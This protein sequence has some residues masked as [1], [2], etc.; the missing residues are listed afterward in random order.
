MTYVKFAVSYKELDDDLVARLKAA[1]AELVKVRGEAQQVFLKSAKG[2]GVTAMASVKYNQPAV[3]FKWPEISST[4]PTHGF[5]VS[6]EVT[7]DYEAK[8]RFAVAPAIG[9]KTM[10]LLLS[11][12]LL[13]DAEKKALI[14]RCGVDLDD[15]SEKAGA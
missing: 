7:E 12:K 15:L 8:N 2:L 11:G 9:E 5:S 3:T 10:N 14:K 4:V 13:T 1:E 6:L